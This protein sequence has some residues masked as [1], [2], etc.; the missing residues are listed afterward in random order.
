LKEV[1]VI[2]LGGSVLNEVKY[3]RLLAQDI[4]CITARG[5]CP[6]IVHGGGKAITNQL[7]KM[8]MPHDFVGGYR[9]TSEQAMN[10]IE[11][12]LSGRVNKDL[13][14]AF[15]DQGIESIGVCG[16]TLNLFEVVKKLHRGVDL[17]CVGEIKTVRKKV[18]EIL[19]EN[20]IT[21]VVAPLGQGGQ[22]TYNINADDVA[23]SIAVAVNAKK[24]IYVSDIEGVY[25]DFANKSSIIK[26]ID[27]KSLKSLI[28][29]GEFD[30]GMLPKLINCLK[31]IDQ[32][33]ET[34]HIISGCG[35][36]NIS[37]LL[38]EGDHVGTSI[39]KG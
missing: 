18:L 30:G 35:D 3:R 16:K 27:D 11:M 10:E 15:S 1:I 36:K 26:N 20:K 25:R 6:I 13:V 32:S 33:V 24:L 19:L 17:G 29:R 9:R 7:D 12:V 31:A 5:Y 34:C 22:I 39:T 28:D 2:K 21:P 23:Q 8:K 37:Q 38:I 4:R 14:S